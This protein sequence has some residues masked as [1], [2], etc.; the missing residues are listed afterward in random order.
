MARYDAIVLGLGAMGSATLYQLAKRGARVLGIDRYSP[1]HEKGS[2]HG[3]TRVTRL[4]IGEGAHYTPLVQRSHEI[5]REIERE[6]G[7]DLLTLNGGLIVSSAAKSSFTHVPQFFENT[8]AA[9][10]AYGIAHEM[11]DT[12]ALRQRFPQL[13]IRNGETGYYEPS[14]G[15][16]RPEACIDAQLGLARKHGAEIHAGERVLFFEESS[17][18]VGVTTDRATYMAD[19]L[20]VAA[21]PWLPELLD[22]R[23]AQHFKIY[24]QALF[25]FDA[26]DKTGMFLPDRFPIFIWELQQS[27]QGIYGFPAIEGLQ[28]GVKIAT[29]QYASTTSADEASRAISRDEIT[30]MYETYVAPNFPALNGR[31]IKAMSCLYTVTPDSQ[32]VIDRHPDMRRV[33]VASPCSGHGFKHSAAIGEALA[34]L[35]TG[36]ESPFDLSPFRLSRF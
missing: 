19:T 27:R 14:A 33:T 2:T 31:C 24:R 20:I 16:V 8:V 6:T 18:A 23:L 34:A 12:A 36:G 1:P 11:L 9:A 5:W 10:E 22:E 35:A 32:F 26:G 15:F 3:D 7:A 28:G 30:A 17:D 29:E 21:G 25:W 4:A 13:A